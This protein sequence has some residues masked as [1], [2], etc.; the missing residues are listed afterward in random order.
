M[1]EEIFLYWGSGSVPCWRVQIVLE[2]KG[3]NYGSKMLSF[4]KQEHKNEDI[5]KLNPR[6]QLPT[7]KVNESSIN[8]SIA[9]SL[10]FEVNFLL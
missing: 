2:E 5:L 9:A 4:D 3:V 8:D 7:I 10:Y 1:S 6:G